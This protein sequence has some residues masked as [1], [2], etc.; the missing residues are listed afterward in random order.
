M[1]LPEEAG[2]YPE[3]VGLVVADPAPDRAPATRSL[4]S[5]SRVQPR[6]HDH[7][8]AALSPLSLTTASL[9]RGIKEREKPC[10]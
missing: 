6:S 10:L 7:R 2:E 3:G 9:G 5:L 4:A 1:Q 8:E